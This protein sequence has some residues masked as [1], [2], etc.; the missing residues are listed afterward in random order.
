[1]ARKHRG[2]SLIELLFVMAIM[3]LMLGILLPAAH[4]LVEAVHALGPHH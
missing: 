3:L 2:I 4:K 1:M